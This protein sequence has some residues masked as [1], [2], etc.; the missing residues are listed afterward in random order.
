MALRGA[1][2]AVAWLPAALSGFGRWEGLYTIF[3]HALALIPGIPGDYLRVAF[4]RLTLHECALSSRISFGTFFA[5]PEASV[6]PGAYI[7]CYCILGKAAIGRNVQIA[8]GVQILSGNG[9]HVRGR[10]GRLSGAE[11]GAFHRVTIGEECWIGAASVVM[12]DVGAGSTVGAG[13]VVVRPIPP[14][15]VAVGSPAHVLRSVTDR[16]FAA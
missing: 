14:N 10:D 13:S 15:S 8:S 6:G 9:Q 5:H 11:K 16:D 2:L 3:A 1:S 12:A 4:Y 7:G